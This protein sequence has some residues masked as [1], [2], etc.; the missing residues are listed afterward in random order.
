MRRFSALPFMAILLSIVSCQARKPLEADNGTIL[1][2]KKFKIF[3][4]IDTPARRMQEMR[5]AFT[6]RLDEI[7]GE[8][9]SRASYAFFETGMDE[10]KAADI[11][12][13]IQRRKPDLICAINH[14]S[15]FADEQIADALAEPRYRFVS[16]NAVSR[17]RRG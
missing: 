10:K 5:D 3:V 13:K 2:G 6:A 15:G 8:A 12:K 14:P 16:E 17:I 11:R 9:N 1:P 4:V 7:L